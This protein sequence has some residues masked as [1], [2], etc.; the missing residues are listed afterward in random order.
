MKFHGGQGPRVMGRS[1]NV[2]A[3]WDKASSS[4]K[5]MTRRAGEIWG[6]PSLVI[7]TVNRS[8]LHGCMGEDGAPLGVGVE[9]AEG[10]Q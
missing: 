4:L 1:G 9:V 7:Q 10:L 2:L 6:S 3:G 8:G 5:M